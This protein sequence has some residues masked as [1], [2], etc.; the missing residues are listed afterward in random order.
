MHIYCEEFLNCQ[1]NCSFFKQPEV[2]G[3]TDSVNIFNLS[4]RDGPVCTFPCSLNITCL[5]LFC[6]VVSWDLASG[7]SIRPSIVYKEYRFARC[8]HRREGRLVQG[9]LPIILYM[10]SV[11]SKYSNAYSFLRV[12]YNNAFKM[13]LEPPRHCSASTMFT[14]A[15]TD[16]FQAILRNRQWC[17]WCA[18]S[19]TASCL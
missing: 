12:Q 15:Y 4:F 11:D 14:A 10:Q 13:L 8:T 1:W 3:S 7:A 16:G 17:N 19:P 5:V 9:L 2:S 18:S 6:H